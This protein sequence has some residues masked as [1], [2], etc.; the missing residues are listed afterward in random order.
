[1]KKLFNEYRREGQEGD[2]SSAFGDMVFGKSKTGTGAAGSGDGGTG[3][4][5]ASGGGQ[6]TGVAAP[7]QEQIDTDTKTYE[8]LITKG[9]TNLDEAEKKTLADLRGKYDFKEVDEEGKEITPEAKKAEEERQKKIKDIQT[10]PEGQRT[11]EEVKF[12]NDNVQKEKTI[13]EQV[14]ELTGA[15]IV[16]DYGESDPSSPEGVVKR[17]EAIRDQ[18]IDSFEKQLQA[19]YPIAYQFL[20]HSQAG[21]SPESFFTVNSDDWSKVAITKEDKAAQETLYRKAL[22]LRGTPQEQID[23]FVTTA[24]DKGKLFEWSSNEL[25]ELQRKQTNESKVREEQVKQAKIQEKA[26]VDNFY[27]NINKQLEKGITGVN[28]PVAE[29]K[30]FTEFFT[31]NTFVRE[32]QL[33]FFKALN[34]AELEQ[35]LA[36]AYF[37]FKKT[38]LSDIAERKAK[39]IIAGNKRAVV[40]HKL[41]PRASG[42]AATTTKV[43]MKD[44]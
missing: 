44:I 16:V 35:E 40:R 20:L 31:N 6:G 11:L 5:A 2:G 39:S 4:G 10:K 27:S 9:E 17:E 23:L 29:R 43:A 32:G 42:A 8:A 13:Y 21:G 33:V 26:V 18:A 12:L 30:A 25:A 34:P 38:N 7:T 1:M 3:G 15:P 14:D 41:V 22:A 37:S 24:K 28:I 36:A 19:E